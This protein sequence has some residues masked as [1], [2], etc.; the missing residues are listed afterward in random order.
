MREIS[1]TWWRSP[2][3]MKNLGDEI[4]PIL[5]RD[6]FN[7]GFFKTSVMKA[8]LLST[9]SILSWAYSRPKWPKNR[10]EL[11]VIGSGF[12]RPE[13]ISDEKHANLDFLRLISVRGHLTRHMLGKYGEGLSLG[14]PGLLSSLLYRKRPEKKFTAGVIP[15]H[16]NVDNPD[17]LDLFSEFDNYKIIDFRTDDYT[18][19]FEEMLSCD[20][21]ISQS[22]HGLII[23][24]SFGIPNAWLDNGKLHAGGEFKFHD[25]FSS[26]DRPFSKKIETNKKV[27]I[28]DVDSAIFESEQ[29]KITSIQNDIVGAFNS[30]FQKV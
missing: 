9:G 29:L 14:D 2:E 25:Y 4:T 22:L 17:F 27:K 11:Y 5:L 8:D 13:P 12:M 15:H 3:G 21:I 20:I 16:S 30:F 18:S 1:A 26:I 24:D 6:Y 28:S 19:V 10:Q 23:S 7:V